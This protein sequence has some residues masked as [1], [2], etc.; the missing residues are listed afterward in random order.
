[1]KTFLRVKVIHL[2]FWVGEH[3]GDVVEPFDSVKG[4]VRDDRGDSSSL[5]AVLR[6]LR[7]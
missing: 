5:W 4:V 6:V 7:A 1:M 3:A 2:T